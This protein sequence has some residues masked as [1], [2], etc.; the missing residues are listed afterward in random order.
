MLGRFYFLAMVSV[1]GMSC[2]LA[3]GDDG[4]IGG[5]SDIDYETTY[6]NLLPENES[7]TR[8]GDPVYRI[9]GGKPAR[10]GAWPSMVALIFRNRAICGG[11]VI[12]KN[13]VLTAAHC[14][15][16]RDIAEF[17]IEEGTV[18][19][20]NGGRRI[21]LADIIINPRY[22]SGPPTN[23]TALLKLKSAAVSPGQALLHRRADDAA[24]NEGELATIV[25]FGRILP[26]PAKS[27]PQVQ[28]G[29]S[30][31]R[32]L[33]ADVPIISTERCQSRYGESRVTTA[34][35]CAGFE[36]GQSD[37]CQG[38]SGGP[39]LYRG[40]LAETIQIGVVSWGAGCA[41]PKSYG[42]YASVASAENWIRELVPAA[43]FVEASNKQ[44]TGI[45]ATLSSIP[46]YLSQ[47]LANIVGNT[48][49]SKPSTLAQLSL[50][51]LA[52]PKLNLGDL[53]QLRIISSVDGNLAVFN[54]D[55]DGTTYQIFPNRFVKNA[56]SGRIRSGVPLVL[57]DQGDG[58]RLRA[59]PPLGKSTIIA[60]VFPPET[61]ISDITKLNDSLG[62]IDDPKS[63]FESLADR[64]VKTRGIKVE[65]VAP[66]NRAI[67]Q[68]T[69]ELVK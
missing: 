45:G 14:V 1:F 47:A 64:E 11:T 9:V 66:V 27:G 33:Q 17:E 65:P 61:P 46:M 43:K 23:D 24:P 3:L 41:Q 7:M 50:E 69:Y 5:T 13:W 16:N 39:L 55:P 20:N 6:R 21:S 12:D 36:E 38:D 25:G 32:L 29:A 10:P 52:G 49:A 67:A 2:T 42:V 28:T 58:F 60:L 35:L 54:R 37:A 68:L 34:N 22:R 48:H 30:S 62:K 18:E 4:S 19:L 8:G 59:T 51:L 56:G 40:A 15:A 63:L 44:G 57:P 31:D 53:I 26:R